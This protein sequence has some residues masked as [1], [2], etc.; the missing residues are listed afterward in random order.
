MENAG[1]KEELERFREQIKIQLASI[2]EKDKDINEKTQSIARL[3]AEL[4]D[5]NLTVEKLHKRCAGLVA[6]KQEKSKQLDT[7]RYERAQKEQE[8]RNEIS[9]VNKTCNEMKKQV[10]LESQEKLKVTRQLQQ[11]QEMINEIRLAI[12]AAQRI[13]ENAQAD[14]KKT[15]AEYEAKI[16]ALTARNELLTKESEEAVKTVKNCG[17]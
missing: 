9:A 1:N 8:L 6:D 7:E 15:Q 5:S 16:A 2:S 3:D 12:E 13:N 10:D 17:M 4:S 14:L 11:S